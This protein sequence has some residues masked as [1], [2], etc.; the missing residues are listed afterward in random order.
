MIIHKIMPRHVNAWKGKFPR[1]SNLV[2]LILSKK[3]I[4]EE[5]NIKR[6]L[7]CD[8]IFFKSIESN[9]ERTPYIICKDMCLYEYI[10]ATTRI[11]QNS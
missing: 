3:I 7:K 6:C 11:N 9:K 1:H 10:L 5:G 4:L 2:S 8:W